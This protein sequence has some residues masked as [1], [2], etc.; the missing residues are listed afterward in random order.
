[1]PEQ[2]V[3]AWHRHITRSGTFESICVVGEGNDD[4]LYAIVRRPILGTIPLTSITS[5]GTTATVTFSEN[6][7]LDSGQE[8]TVSGA[9]QEAYNGTFVVAVTSDTVVTY[10]IP[11]SA[12][13]PATGTISVT[14]ERNRRYVE[15]MASR[16]FGDQEDYFGVDSG[17]TY[18]GASATVIS[19]LDHLEGCDVVIY[20]NGAV[21]PGKTVSGGEITLDEATT[22]AHIGLAVDALAETLPVAAE[23][24]AYAQSTI[25]NVGKVSMRVVNSGPFKVGPD[26]S[27]LTEAK[28][29]TT[30]AYGSPPA[31][32]TGEVEVSVTGS[33]QDDGTVIV[34]RSDPVPV[35]I[36]SMTIELVFGG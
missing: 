12:V 6:H 32:K 27:R 20:A 35:T 11:E 18:D 34:R 14:G 29:R 33:W 7:L 5:S 8:I 21:Q 36:T 2:E 22:Y 9:A 25:K 4:M 17:L 15:Q 30:E 26:T 19:G 24:E 10:T 23:I 13:T 3:Y 1:V 31:L 16:L 28:I